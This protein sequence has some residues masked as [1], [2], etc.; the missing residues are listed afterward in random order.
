MLTTPPP[1]LGLWTKMGKA[2]GVG[3]NNNLN[4]FCKT[5]PAKSVGNILS[6]KY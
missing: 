4:K 5:L 1:Q 6:L 3:K 2:H